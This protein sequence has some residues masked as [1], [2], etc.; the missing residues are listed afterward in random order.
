M[1]LLGLFVINSSTSFF[2]GFQ[3]FQDYMLFGEI[4]EL[5][6]HVNVAVSASAANGG[7]STKLL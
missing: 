2:W 6:D 7:T 3:C 4:H 1:V 5:I